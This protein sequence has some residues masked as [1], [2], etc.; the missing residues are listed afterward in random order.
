MEAAL[1]EAR[2]GAEEGS[3]PTGTAL[4]DARGQLVAT[5]RNRRVQDRAVVMYGEINCLYNAGKTVDH[6]RR[7]TM[8]STLKPR[9]MCVGAIA[10]FGIARV[11]VNINGAEKL[12][13]WG[14]ERQDKC[15]FVRA[16]LYRMLTQ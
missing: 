7:M 11:I 10:Q 9:N 8:Y 5:G 15:H 1:R 6:F 16:P 4:V 14:V 3:I 12:G 13:H 2:Q